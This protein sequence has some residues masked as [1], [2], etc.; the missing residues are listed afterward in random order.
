MLSEII[1]GTEYISTPK[2]NGRVELK[3]NEGFWITDKEITV[4]SSF[5]QKIRTKVPENF[6]TV[7]DEEK[8]LAEQLIAEYFDS[9]LDFE[10]EGVDE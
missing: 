10:D 3:A 8:V 6:G 2:G 5:F 7:T 1:T 9:L 4:N